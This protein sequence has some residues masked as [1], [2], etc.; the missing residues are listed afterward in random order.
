[1]SARRKARPEAEGQLVDFE[2]PE[3]EAPVLAVAEPPAPVRA[4]DFVWGGQPV[5]RCRVCGRYERVGNLEAVERHEVEAHTKAPEV[6]ESR[7]VGTDGQPLLV[8][9]QEGEGNV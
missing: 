5:Y 9:A 1:M 3:V 2:R 6:R 4:P 7:I 8:A